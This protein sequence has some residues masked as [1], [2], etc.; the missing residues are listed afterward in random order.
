MAI[1]KT[2]NYFSIDIDI[3]TGEERKEQRSV[4][5]NSNAHTNRKQTRDN[6]QQDT[7]RRY[8]DTKQQQRIFIT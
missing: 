5:K 4:N 8:K 2:R 1:A 7:K 6:C 3:I